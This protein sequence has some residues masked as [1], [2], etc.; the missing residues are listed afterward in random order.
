[1]HSFFSKHGLAVRAIGIRVRDAEEA[2]RICVANGGES[3]QPPVQL[4]DAPTGQTMVRASLV[5]YAY[6]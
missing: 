6:K 2:Y 3:I 1:M 5:S 4:L